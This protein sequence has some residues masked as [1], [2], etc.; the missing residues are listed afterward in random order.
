MESVAATSSP[1]A[2]DLRM[3]VMRYELISARWDDV[4]N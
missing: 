4:P 2:V 3:R 1:D